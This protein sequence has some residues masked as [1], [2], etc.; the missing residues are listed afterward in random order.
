MDK[1]VFDTNFILT[2]IK[3]KIDFIHELE[4]CELLIPEQV[5]EELEK[6]TKSKR[7]SAKERDLA[8]IA[9]S[10]L[11]NFEKRFIKIKLE[12]K[13]VD[14][15]FLKLKNDDRMIVATLDNEIKKVLRGKFKFL[16]IRNKKK[17]EVIG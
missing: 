2:C 12:K 16:T 15:G 13:F 4:D 3:Q 11:K 8:K 6:L 9:L 10:L 7:K 5:L 1:I 17:L 14:A